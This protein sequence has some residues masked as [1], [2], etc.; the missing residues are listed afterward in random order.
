MAN[1]PIPTSWQLLEKCLNK[2]RVKR[3]LPIMNGV[4][5]GILCQVCFCFYVLPMLYILFH[6]LYLLFSKRPLSFL[7]L[8]FSI[9]FF[10]FQK[11]LFYI[12]RF[13]ISTIL[14]KS[15]VATESL[16]ISNF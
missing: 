5:L 16:R 1:K 10:L 6:L 15:H 13:R 11:N 14:S 12:S 7:F 3:T 9:K 8:I 4:E 2:E